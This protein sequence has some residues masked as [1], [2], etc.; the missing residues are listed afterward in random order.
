[1]P[2]RGWKEAM[3]GTAA[4]DGLRL[5]VKLAHAPAPALSTI[6]ERRAFIPALL[7]ATL[8]ALS[9][10]SLLVPRFDFD[11]AVSEQLDHNPKSADMT[12]H[13][14]EEALVA[15]RRI[16]VVGAYAS[17]VLLPTLKALAIAFCLWLAL[18]VAGGT[19]ELVPT[20]A[21]T[22]FA[23][24]P[25][26][27][28]SLLTIPAILVQPMLNADSVQKL[29]PTSP[30]FFEAGPSRWTLAL[31]AVDLFSLG[32]VVLLALGASQVAN[33]STKRAAIVV[34][35]LWVAYVGVVKIALPQLAGANT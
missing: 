1:M 21:V 35:V 9:Y 33:V 18:K 34:S 17:A 2:G 12:P 30:A 32:C 20:I 16:G 31:G 19:P 26:S 25:L 15:G 22:S 6:A 27:L 29:L 8:L 4:L 7:I 28:E 5:V 3:F 24:L 23:L 10:T 14:R 11:S 13:Q